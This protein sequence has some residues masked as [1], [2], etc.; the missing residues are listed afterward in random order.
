MNKKLRFILIPA[1][2]LTIQINS[3][4]QDE[5]FFYVN[6]GYVG[7]TYKTLTSGI[8]TWYIPGVIGPVVPVKITERLSGVSLGG[9]YNLQVKNFWYKRLDRL[10]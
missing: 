2:L 3:F 1:L 5:N 8:L 10:C 7:T 4:C 6:A 9:G